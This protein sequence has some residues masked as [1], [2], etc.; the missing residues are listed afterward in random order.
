MAT[1]TWAIPA[2][3]A[4]GAWRWFMREVRYRQAVFSPWDPVIVGKII[5][6]TQE[7]VAAFQR[8]IRATQKTSAAFGDVAIHIS[9]A[10]PELRGVDQVDQA[11]RRR[12]RP[13]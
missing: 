2:V 12:I 10:V 3:L 8:M 4:L 1:L 9:E 11:L 5:V 7:M 6:A 13:T